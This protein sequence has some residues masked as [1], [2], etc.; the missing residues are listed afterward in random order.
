MDGVAV[1]HAAFLCSNHNKRCSFRLCSFNL[2]HVENLL[3]LLLLQ[4]FCLWPFCESGWIYS[5]AVLYFQLATV[6]SSLQ[7][8]GHLTYSQFA[9][10]VTL[11]FEIF[12]A[13][14][15]WTR[16]SQPPDCVQWPAWISFLYSSVSLFV[17]LYGV[18]LSLGLAIRYRAFIRFWVSVR[19]NGNNNIFQWINW[20]TGQ[21]FQV[22]GV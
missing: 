2:L 4:P 18:V 8:S 1:E 20:C 19:C 5:F 11:S 6:L 10:L 13:F 9:K 22:L 12:T 16:S 21:S 7:P 3:Y 17:T 14:Y 15:R